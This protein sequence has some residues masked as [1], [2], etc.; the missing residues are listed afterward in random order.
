[1][2]GRSGATRRFRVVTLLLALLPLAA[3]ACV[4]GAGAIVEDPVLVPA[5]DETEPVA[6]AGDAADD[7]AIWVHPTS[8]GQS[9]IIGNDKQ[10]ALE[11]YNLDGSR[12]QR[13][14][15]GTAFWGNVDVR[16]GVTIGG[17]TLDVA[18]VYNGGLRLFTVN[19]ATR[20][21]QLSTDNG[22]LLSAPLGEGLCLY[23]S[24]VSNEL[25]LYLISRAKRIR[26]YRV[27]DTDR[28]GLLQVKF[29][30]EFRLTSEAEGCVADDE[31][32]RLYVDQEDVGLWR[33]GAE[34]TDSTTGTLIDEVQP[35][36][37]LAADAEGVTMVDTG[38][39]GGYI[40]AS[41]QNIADPRNSYFVVY[42]RATNAYLGSFRI[43][44]GPN[45]DAC[46]RT[47]GIT[48]YAGN[49]G[50]AF[51]AGLFVCQDNGNRSPS[52]NQDFKLTR[53]DKILA[54]LGA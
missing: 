20:R 43:V 48:A 21:L 19:S 52:A 4:D 29:L 49:L 39:Q 41:A 42:N 53:L 51:P 30:R 11:T 24:Q 31:R 45:A 37:H 5:D 47:D 28:D 27:H 44:N 1:M 38:G 10:G 18:A 13:I 16:Q 17:Q 6:H 40:I 2:T 33:F 32:G 54:A 3:A 7:P 25:Y 36:G 46:E 34:P 14:T 50:A 23:D 26:L 9:L 35:D 12:E 8:P 22:G 15:T